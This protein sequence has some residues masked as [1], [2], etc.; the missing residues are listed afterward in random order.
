[1]C[2][3]GRNLREF[4]ESGKIGEKWG[5][6]AKLPTPLARTRRNQAIASKTAAQF[7]CFGKTRTHPEN[8][9][10]REQE[11]RRFRIITTGST[12]TADFSRIPGRV[13][14]FD[15]CVEAV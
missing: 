8:A 10:I 15:W 4:C 13:R 11:T 7:F 1:M 3:K 12:Q 6:G 2:L 14:H 5:K 9:T